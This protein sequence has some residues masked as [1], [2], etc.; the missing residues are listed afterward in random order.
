MSNL[1]YLNIQ[2]AMAVAI[3]ILIYRHYLRRWFAAQDFASAVLPLLVLHAFRYLG[4][5]LLVTGQIA[6]T[7]PRDALQI[8][9]YGDFASAVCAFIAAI[10]ISAR[11]TP[12][13]RARCL[14]QR[15]GHG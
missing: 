14:V 7:V 2:F 6:P 8:M 15:G 13:P 12:C 9:A 4:L 1:I 3:Y 5:S 10:A 11:S